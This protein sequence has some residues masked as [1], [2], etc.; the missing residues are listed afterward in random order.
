MKNQ[1]GLTLI[2]WILILGIIA[3]FATV[4]MRMLPMYQE[5]YS[6]LQIM[7]GMEVEIKNN[8]LTKQQVM[9]LL[10]K[11]F[12]TGYVFSVNKDNVELS[13]GK[14]NVYVTKIVIDYEVR[15]PFMAQIDLIGH[16]H[17]EVDVEPKRK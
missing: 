13:R 17:T 8:K 2:S 11:R 3:F 12:N 6:V 9:T 7:D 10:Q 5:Y 14:D 16:F 1:R 15:K 4:A